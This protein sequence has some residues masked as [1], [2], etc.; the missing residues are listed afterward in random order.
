MRCSANKGLTTHHQENTCALET[1]QSNVASGCVRTLCTVYGTGRAVGSERCCSSRQALFGAA[2]V[3]RPR[4]ALDAPPESVA[5]GASD[6]ARNCARLP[7][8]SIRR[9]FAVAGNL[10]LA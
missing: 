5:A 4:D 3:A 2:P 6:G 9:G 7:G 10:Y 1:E 8:G